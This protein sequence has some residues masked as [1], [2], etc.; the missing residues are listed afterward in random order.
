MTKKIFLP[1]NRYVT[2]DDDDYNWLKRWKW[3][4]A[5]SG[6]ATTDIKYNDGGK[7]GYCKH[8]MHRLINQTP[9]GMLTDHINGNKLDN[10]K[11]NLR[12]VNATQNKAN[13][14][15]WRPNKIL[16][17]VEKHKSGF[18]AAVIY[19]GIRTR[20]KTYHTPEEAYEAYIKMNE[21]RKKVAFE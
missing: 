4:I 18:R 5:G 21:D 20:S 7:C 1:Q 17:G 10:R 14:V 13:I 9:E 6:Y 2:V 19:M 16:P 3:H 8:R 11:S 12:T 15:S